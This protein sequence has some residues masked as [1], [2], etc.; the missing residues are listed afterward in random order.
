MA[1]VP[2]DFLRDNVARYRKLA[3]GE[4]VD[5]AP[6]R[7]WLDNTFVCA[8]T[9]VN[10]AEYASS[11]EVMLGA[12]KMV[13]DRFYDL[14]DFSVDVDTTDL[15]FDYEKFAADHPKAIPHRVLEE[16]LDNF[17][18]YFSRRKITELKGL[19]RL[20][21]GIEFFNARLPRHKQVCHYLGITGCMD[22]FSIFRG[23]TDFFTDLCDQPDKVHQIFSFLTERS[24]EWLEFAEDT[25]GPGEKDN[26]LFDKI[27]VG[28][29]YCAYLPPDLFDE[30]V[31]PYT[32]RLFGAY[33]GRAL[34]SLHTDGDI[35]PRAMHKLADVGIDELMGFSPNQ[36]IKLFREA[37]PD[38]ILGGNIHPIKV[39]IYGTPDDVKAAAKYCFESA[40]QNQRFV[41]CTGGAISAGAKPENVDAFIEATYEIVKY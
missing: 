7:L 30:F 34:C 23:T 29:D 36:D 10:P 4:P 3:K 11:F 35:L 27:D 25:W 15:F 14:R 16:S 22:L 18:K 2:V 9:K 8:H 12:Q 31:V 5:Y 20:L 40:N 13:N 19:K 17:D 21:E 41:L 38:V 28:E 6:F 1:N 39:M 37:L 24:L 33:K 32:G 26:V